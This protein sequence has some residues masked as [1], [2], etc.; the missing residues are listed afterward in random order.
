MQRRR[1][2]CVVTLGSLGGKLEVD[3]QRR[4]QPL[5]SAVVEVLLDPP[6][7][8]VGCGKNARARGGQLA[9]PARARSLP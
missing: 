2:H 3:P 9:D 5:L 1:V 8:A 6:P 4:D 7:L